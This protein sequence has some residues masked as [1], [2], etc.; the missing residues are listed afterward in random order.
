MEMS[1]K[2]FLNSTIQQ[3]IELGELDEF[4][5]YNFSILEK[6]DNL[7][8]PIHNILEHDYLDDLK[9]LSKKY[10]MDDEQFRKYRYRPQVLAY[11]LYQNPELYFIIL[12]IND[13]TTKKEFDQKEI[14]IIDT[15]NLFQVLNTIY[16]AQ[17]EFIEDNRANL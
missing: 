5:N 16:N 6:I 10:I 12:L 1:N 7:E 9:S 3:Y 14:Y 11:D 15:Q 8:V 13:M 17:T 4:S 2:P